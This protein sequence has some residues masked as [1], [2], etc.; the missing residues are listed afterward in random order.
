MK[1]KSIELDEDEMPERVLVEMTL[2][3]AAVVYRLTGGIAPRTVS[4]AL[5]GTRWGEA[6]DGVATCLSGA[7]FNRFWDDGANEVVPPWRGLD[8]TLRGALDDGDE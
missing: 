6:L 2:D 3:E 4:R 8:A 7:F 1:V 5:L